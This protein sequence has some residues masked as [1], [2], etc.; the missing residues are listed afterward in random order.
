MNPLGLALVKLVVYIS[1]SSS[2]NNFQ[3]TIAISFLVH[4]N[5]AAS[6]EQI[7]L[8]LSWTD[9][10]NW[11]VQMRMVKWYDKDNT[12]LVQENAMKWA[13]VAVVQ[14]YPSCSLTNLCTQHFLIVLLYVKFIG[15]YEKVNLC[16]LL[17][18]LINNIPKHVLVVM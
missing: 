12:C 6:L 9:C 4:L 1:S 18:L 2:V 15:F 3:V 13:A 14:G 11:T 7:P 10:P 16:F 5:T 8:P 17:Q